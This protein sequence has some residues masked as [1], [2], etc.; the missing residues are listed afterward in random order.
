MVL[1]HDNRCPGTVGHLDAASAAASVNA[2]R[3]LRPAYLQGIRGL[4]PAP[5]DT[6]TIPGDLAAAL[7]SR[8]GI[9]LK[10]EAEAPSED[11]ILLAVCPD[12]SLPAGLRGVTSDDL[13][14]IGPQGYVLHADNHG[15]VLAAQTVDGL[16]WAVRSLLQI[17]TDRP[18][19]PGL[20]IRDWP[21]LPYR[22]AHLDIS[23]G[24]VPTL[25]T[26]KRLVDVLA[27]AKINILELYI[28]H[29]FKFRRHPDI[30]PPEGLSPEEGRELFDYAA[31][32][33]VEVHPMFQVL[34]HSYHI[35]SKPQYQ[36]LRIGP[37]EK[38]PWIMTF[39][40]RKPEAVAMVGEM[41][42]ELCETFPGKFFTVDITEIDCDGLKAAGMTDRADHGPGVRIRAQAQADGGKKHGMRLI[43]AQGPLDSVGH[44]AGMGPKLEQ[45]PKDVDR[46][47]LLLR[48]RRRISRRGRRISRGCG[49]TASTS[50]PR[51]GSTATSGILPWADHAADFSDLEVRRGLAHG[52]IGSTTSDWGDEGHFHFTGQTWYPFMYHGASAWTG[53]AGRPRLFRS[54]VH[55]SALRRAGRSVARAIQAGRQHQRPEDQSPRC[56]RQGRR[57]GLGPLLGV[58]PRPVQRSRDRLRW[59]IRPRPGERSSSPPTRL[60][61]CWKP[62][63]S[64]ATRNRDNLEQ[65]L[66]GVRCYQAM[67][68]KLI[69]R[70]PLPGY[71]LPAGQASGRKCGHWRRLQAAATGFQAT[72]AGRGPRERQVPRDGRLVRSDHQPL[73]TEAQRVGQGREM[74]ACGVHRV[75]PPA[76]RIRSRGCHAL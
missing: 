22:G 38:Q 10:S 6:Q 18:V 76:T 60:C 64:K 44:L 7:S 66:F 45:L 15:I 42:D 16:R 54:G 75:S 61:N 74:T 35:L 57:E 2:P 29:V 41:I 39:D 36:H 70:R 56:R 59:P 14:A 63:S 69:M 48:R 11:S 40:I 33:G 31:R 17:S 46:G 34:G 43:I 51:P 3:H 20:H 21:A 13:E 9:H 8:C 24:Q 5:A 73:Q 27:E 23:R 12:Q 72:L 67:G 47:E 50:S 26:L 53:G 62:P 19:L 65:L 58:L 68:R 4:K 32:R 1:L 55:S 52:A 71:R 49:R 37:C 30:S 25:A 28:E